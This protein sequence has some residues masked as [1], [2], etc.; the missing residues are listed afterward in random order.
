MDNKVKVK[1]ILRHDSTEG[2]SA[3]GDSVIL[4]KGEIGLEYI[5][6]ENVPKIKIGDGI[7]PWNRLS[8]F[9][10]GLPENY[11]WGSL[12]GIDL[13][14]NSSFTTN[15]ELKKPGYSDVV[16][17][18]DINNNYD[19]LDATAKKLDDLINELKGRFDSLITNY[20]E[21]ENITIENELKDVRVRHNGVEYSCAGAAVRAIDEELTN[22]SQELSSFV[23]SSV[24][25]GLYY[26][27]NLLYLTSNNEII[28]SPVEI[29]G[30]T[31][32]GGG[33]GSSYVINLINL[34]ESRIISVSAGSPVVL[35]YN[36]TSLDGDKYPDG[37]GVGILFINNI[38]QSS[39]S[40]PQGENTLDITQYLKN[41]ANTVKLQVTNS[42][43]SYRVL[44]YTVN[45]L[46]LSITS[47]SPSMAIYNT[48][49]IGFQYTVTGS[50]SKDVFLFIDGNQIKTETVT[51]SGQSRQ[52][53]IPRLPDGAHIIEV[54]AISN[55]EG[56]E[57]KSNTI[58]SGVIWY[59]NETSYPIILINSNLEEIQQGETVT[60]PYIIF[61]PHYETASIT[62]EIIK[63]DGTLYRPAENLEVNRAS[64]EWIT[65]D[66]PEGKV[67]FKITCENIEKEYS[68]NVLPSTFDKEIYKEGLLLEFNAVGRNNLETN[69][70]SWS[71]GDIEAEFSQIGWNNI[72][73]WLTDKKGQPMLRLL[74]NSSVHI[75][76]EPF[77]QNITQTGY[78]IEVE[79][80]TQNVSDYDSVITSSFAENIGLRI[81]SQS[82]SL[83]STGTEISA[84]FKEDERVRLTFVIEQNILID[85]ISTSNRLMYIYINGVLCGIQQYGVNDIFIQ[86]TEPAGISIGAE[87]CGIDV[88]YI[89]F[90]NSAFTA[91][92]QLNN[93]IVD[94]PSLQDRMEINKRNDILDITASDLHKKITIDT[95][96][97]SIPYIV[98]QCPELPQY[99][100]DKKKGMSMYYVDP[101]NPKNN[102]SAVGCQFDV[103]G[104]S[105]AGYPVKNFKIFFKEGI[106]YQQTGKHEDGYFFTENSLESST[107]CL[108]ADYASSESANNVMLVDYYNTICPY[109]MPPQIADERVRQGVYGQPIV[110]FWENTE[111]KEISFEGKYNMNDDK[112]NEKVFGF[113]DIDFSSIIPLAEQRIECWEWRNNNTAPCLFQDDSAFNE[114][115]YDEEEKMI[116]PKW[117]QSFEPRFPDI[118]DDMNG[119]IDAFRRMI[120]WVVSTNTDKVSNEKT[121]NNILGTPKYY[122]TRD[123]EWDANKT[124]YTDDKGTV[125][126]I[127]KRGFIKSYNEKVSI[128]RD[129]FY[130]KMGA[131]SYEDLVGGYIFA[132]DEV[133]KLWTLYKNDEP[134][135]EVTS[136]SLYGIS[137]SDSSI[138]SFAFEYS[139]GGEGWKNGLYEY[140]THDTKNYRLAKFQTEFE[141]YFILEAMVFYYLYTEVFLLMDNRA[142]NMFLTTFNGI[143][144]FPIPYDMDSGLGI[145]N[146]GAL[147][148]DYNLED[149]DQVDGSDVY[150]GQQSVLW[151]NFRQCF[152]NDVRKMYHELRSGSG[153]KE[154]SYQAIADKMNKHQEA[155]AEVIWNLDHEIKYLQPFFAGSDNLA[156]AQGDKKTQRNF[157]LF[158]GFKYRDSKYQAG[159]AV[160]NNI[161]LRLYDKGEIKVTPYS[162]I[163]ARVEFGN[164]KDVTQRAYRNEEITF[165]TE[166]IAAV[167]DLETHIYSSDRIAKLGDLSALKI[168]YCDFSLAPK[169][170][171]IIVG[172]EK[173]GYRNG[174]LKTF[175]L[176]TSDLLREINISNCYNLTA[177]I[178]ASRCPCLE[179]FKAHGSKITGVNF[180]NGGRLKTVRLPETITSLILRNQ[181][182]IEELNVVSYDNL[183][184]LWVENCPKVP[185]EDLIINATN[186]LKNVRLYNVEW[187]TENEERLQLFADKLKN[188]AGLDSNGQVQA[189][190]V[191]TGKVHIN[192]IS[193]EL[194]KTLNEHF[195]EL[196]VIVNG[197]PQYFINYVDA[198]NNIVYSY[199]AAGGTAAIDPV[200]QNLISI[201]DIPLT[202]DTLRTRYSYAGWVNLPEDINKSYTI[203]VNEKIEYLV[204]FYDANDNLFEQAGVAQ[205]VEKGQNAIDPI[206]NSLISIPVKTP[207]AQ[208]SYIYKEWSYSLNKIQAPLDIKPVFDSII[209]KYTVI[210]RNETSP[211]PDLQTSEVE[212]GQVASYNGDVTEIHKYVDG[213]PS[214]VYDFK[215]WNPSD[216]LIQPAN[217]SPLP[218]I[219]TADFIFVGNI[220]D[221]WSEIGANASHGAATYEVGSLKKTTI[222]IKGVPYEIEMELVSK[223]ADQLTTI[224]ENYCGGKETSSY[225]FLA[226]T[227]LPVKLPISSTKTFEDITS[228]N[229]GGWSES[230]LREYINKYVTLEDEVQKVIKSV[231]KIS[232]TGCNGSMNV[233]RLLTTSDKIWIP[234][235]TELGIVTYNGL[236][237]QSYSGH[238][239]DWF[240]DNSSRI[241]T[242]EGEPSSYWTRT[243]LHSL[244]YRFSSVSEEGA[245]ADNLSST[246]LGILI[247]FCI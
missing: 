20:P 24:P 145:N 137:V 39:F 125:C 120:S 178:D 26:E 46:S 216:L 23:G 175:T 60:L 133:T 31:G 234:S 103:Q 159:E 48:D 195:P 225:T 82:A 42:E 237:N 112:S 69:P 174:N 226:K 7:S 135:A 10:M 14:N 77:S 52:F 110:L 124:Y 81:K 56:G 59:S 93:F 152:S 230:D 240:S 11:T 172:S 34:L 96:G 121:D 57:V 217:Y 128:D 138:L 116:R 142:K 190:S 117:A 6:G 223:E 153:E 17:I 136:P 158:N 58:R 163:Y 235:L 239:Y 238:A 85:G 180:S 68:I 182:L 80:A 49:S 97:S 107:L 62:R 206:E 213:S 122:L 61:H 21:G 243:T 29:K 196:I 181:T 28:S 155:W 147:T 3:V 200:E 35:K 54:Y 47:S 91:D 9:S 228:A 15:L 101:I 63:E 4:Y 94:R 16:N 222:Y 156:M 108:K 146:E 164:A 232:D 98:M 83:K 154:F 233:K 207:S 187:E 134:I 106:D 13:K 209:N 184:L 203:R 55:S 53:T 171:E 199:I 75:P 201:E 119:Q 79:L 76:F 99:K 71:Y 179:T 86:Q 105:S 143:H 51:S 36:Y 111:T 132:L 144:W 22:L 149:T 140:Y 25:D 78:T 19:I 50:G 205:W 84:Q 38:Q 70:A 168:G 214:F 183:A 74:P 166:G 245:L 139:I 247:G 95:L 18:I 27:N 197:V 123:I 37:D 236:I 148:F 193:Q 118:G 211:F 150:T 151:I 244:S 73:G 33:S 8:Y 192:S 89:R 72:D 115:Y 45:V 246:Q 44:S 202:E 43:G 5:S 224:D 204:N 102:F 176:G 92:M 160:T 126:N 194:L 198:K 1:I 30:G 114:T 218:I 127:V 100:G 191:L 64:K 165:T 131:S 104:T 231:T 173:E 221:D 212:Y 129:V 167:N 157:W 41:G 113:T 220:E 88:Y 2:W 130:E 170:Q 87:S 161:H 169:L 141:E 210:F 32:T 208:Y 229:A 242:F 67:T 12:L 109:K 40:V 66:L 186:S 185:F 162:H 90:Y 219:F 215:G 227:L 189:K 188:L 65:Q 177:N 241:K